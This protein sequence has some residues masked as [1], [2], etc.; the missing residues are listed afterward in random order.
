MKKFYPLLILLS[1]LFTSCTKN[2]EP[3]IVYEGEF[4]L[5]KNPGIIDPNQYYQNWNFLTPDITT[6]EKNTEVSII[7]GNEYKDFI[8]FTVN[9]SKGELKITT[10]KQ[11]IKQVWETYT[12]TLTF[13]KGSIDYFGYS[14]T[15]TED[16]IFKDSELIQPLSNFELKETYSNLIDTETKPVLT[17]FTG[18]TH[19]ANSQNFTIGKD[20]EE[21]KL[22]YLSPNEI[23][24]SQTLP[25]QRE[26]GTIEQK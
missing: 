10:Q 9:G 1:G 17:Y 7:D 12:K 4:Y 8:V 6:S 16:G 26:I 18:E 20:N 21:Y 24:V 14:I 15:V 23:E 22:T 3:P 5:L 19:Q 25:I 2:E 13:R 11:E